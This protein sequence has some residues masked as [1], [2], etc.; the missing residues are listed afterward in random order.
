MPTA[1]DEIIQLIR[2]I[3]LDVVGTV[4][5]DF[6]PATTLTDDLDLDSLTWLELLGALES[7]TGAEIPEEKLL[8]ILTVGDIVALTQEALTR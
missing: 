4:P 8:Q 6:G 3:T 5:D 1:A 7:R 2:E